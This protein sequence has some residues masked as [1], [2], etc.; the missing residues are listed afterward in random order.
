MDIDDSE[1]DMLSEKWELMT[2]VVK[3]HSEMS[4]ADREVGIL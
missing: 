2:E 1:G 4:K 3:A